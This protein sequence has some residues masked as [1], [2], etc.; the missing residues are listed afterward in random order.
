MRSISFFKNGLSAFELKVLACMFMLIDHI[1]VMLLPQVGALRVIGRLAYPLFAYFIAEGSRYTKN[2]LKR[3]L[4]VFVL[5]VLCQIAFVVFA[6]N[7]AGNILLT[8]SV[9][10]LLIYLL[11][12]TKKMMINSALIGS[13]YLVLFVLSLVAAYYC[14]ELFSLDYGFFGALTPVLVVAFDDMGEWSDKL[15]RVIDRKSVSF[16]ML[17]T[18]LLCIAIFDATM[19]SQIY[20]LLS[21][22]LLALYNGERGKY[23]FKYGFYLFY[24]LHFLGLE[25]IRFAIEL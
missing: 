18:G 2:K 15:Y 8:F 22:I 12:Y 5:G 23:S 1:G 10:I 6:G 19:K 20:S 13:V 4:S 17:A 9:S 21:L 11:M 14:C 24:P 16:I 3:F 25:A 7:G